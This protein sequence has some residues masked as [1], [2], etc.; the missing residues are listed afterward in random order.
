MPDV[1]GGD[2]SCTRNTLESRGTGAAPKLD[3][4]SIGGKS[5]TDH[6]IRDRRQRVSAATAEAK[7]PAF[8]PVYTLIQ[9]STR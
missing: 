9:L 7:Q 6:R 2:A 3:H 4:G 5:I 1:I 8:Q